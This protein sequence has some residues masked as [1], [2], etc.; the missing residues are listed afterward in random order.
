M[1]DEARQVRNTGLEKQLAAATVSAY[2]LWQTPTGRAGVLDSPNSVSSGNYFEQR[3][4]GQWTCKKTAGFVAL[5]G[6]RA[7]WDHSAN[8]INYKKVNDR[9][10][11][12]GRFA[13]DASNAATSCVVDLNADPPYDLDIARDPCLS[14]LVGTAAAG[15]FGY[16]VRRGGCFVLELTAT[17]EAQKVDLLTRDGFDLTANAIVEF[18]FLI[19]NDGSNATQDFTIGAAS[20]T[21]A[22]NFQTITSFVA[23]STVGASTAIN[24]QSD[25]NSTDVAP[26]DT[27][28]TYT[29]G[30][31]VAER[32]EGWLDFR[33]PASVKVYIN[34]VAVLTGTTF[35]AG[36]SGTHY[37]IAHLEKTSG[38]DVYK[39]AVEWLRA[40]YAE[41]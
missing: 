11:Y 27:T 41:Q 35:T 31:S 21:H 23:V 4:D 12:A 26:T 9:D 5:K 32:V 34:G 14:V 6:N 15:G 33:D 18:A 13:E 20:G 17:S 19:E 37:L 28:T 2:E 7:W 36:T 30:T 16:P 38:T 8:A 29:E 10:F 40:H 39:V 24:A 3:T 1:A 22:S 25:D